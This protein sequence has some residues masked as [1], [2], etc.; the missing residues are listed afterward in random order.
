MRRERAVL[1]FNEAIVCIIKRSLAGWQ[2]PP[3][4]LVRSGEGRPSS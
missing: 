2:V 3:Q 4:P 1:V